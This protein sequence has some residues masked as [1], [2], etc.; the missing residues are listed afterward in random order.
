MFIAA[1]ASLASSL[2]SA[3]ICSRD[4]YSE[5]LIDI[6]FFIIAGMLIFVKYTYFII[7]VELKQQIR[8]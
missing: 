1:I 8:Q 6:S 7:F 2:S 5:Y 4:E 3:T